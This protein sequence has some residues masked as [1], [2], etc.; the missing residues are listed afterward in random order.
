VKGKSEWV[1][2]VEVVDGD[3]PARQAGK[4]ATRA[5]FEAAVA[6]FQQRRFAPALERFEALA[7]QFADDAAV[8]IYIE[9]CRQFIEQG[10]PED[11][12]GAAKL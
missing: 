8:G 3:D 7:T 10:I 12:D 5:E 6:E 4:L 2:I 1:E 9:R 11:W